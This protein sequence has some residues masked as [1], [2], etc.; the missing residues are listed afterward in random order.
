MK[1]TFILLVSDVMTYS[2]PV[3]GIILTIQVYVP[4]SSVLLRVEKTTCDLYAL[5]PGLVITELILTRCL[6]PSI[7]A[8]KSSPNEQYTLTLA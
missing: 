2:Y 3:L 6:S 4:E 7:I 1:L 5:K 8:Q